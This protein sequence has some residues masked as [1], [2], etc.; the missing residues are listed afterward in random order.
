MIAATGSSPV[1]PGFFRKARNAV[2]AQS[3]L[4]GEAKAGEKALVI[5][6]RAY[7]L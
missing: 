6:G 3:I 2:V 4:S 5:G 1:F 7:R